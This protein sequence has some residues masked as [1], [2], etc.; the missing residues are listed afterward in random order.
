MAKTPRYV[1][2]N[3]C[4]AYVQQ[5]LAFN[6]SSYT[7]WGTYMHSLRLYAVYSYR[8]SWPL[9]IYSDQTK[10]WYENTDKYSRTT[11]T[12]H[13]QAHPHCDTIGL[14]H[15]DMVLLNEQGP[16]VLTKRRLGVA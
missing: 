11:S 8:H 15:D 2:T 6:N 3:E 7:L 16:V 14:S 10:T 5:R 4:R 9:F 1:P 13:S 12:H